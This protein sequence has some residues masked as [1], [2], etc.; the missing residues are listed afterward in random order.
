MSWT[1]FEK[2][3]VDMYGDLSVVDYLGELMKL[4]QDGTAFDKHLKEFMQL[5]H[6]V[7]GCRRNC[8][9]TRLRDLVR[10]ELLAKQ[11][12]IVVDA[13]CLAWLEE[14][15]LVLLKKGLKEAFTQSLS[16]NTMT[17]RGGA[18]STGSSLTKGSQV[19]TNTTPALNRLNSSR[20]YREA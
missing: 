20:D 6:Q 8:F 10:L 11:P 15:K 2:G 7:H 13:L 9:I 18:P 17:M 4:Q 19:T 12:S 1:K 5:W 16:S 14:E 3:L